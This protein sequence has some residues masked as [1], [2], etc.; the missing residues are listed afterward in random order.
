MITV[1]DKA[2]AAVKRMA[3]AVRDGKP[4]PHSDMAKVIV[5]EMNK[6]HAD[7]YNQAISKLSPI[8]Q[9][10]ISMPLPSALTSEQAHVQ[11]S[12]PNP[13]PAPASV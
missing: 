8:E 1:E 9:K 3:A 10:A 13:D 11:N 4:L 2:M 5:E 12:S 7:Y 6:T